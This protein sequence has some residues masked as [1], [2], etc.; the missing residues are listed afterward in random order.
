MPKRSAEG[1]VLTILWTGILADLSVKLEAFANEACEHQFVPQTTVTNILTRQGI[2]ADTKVREIMTAVRT[3]IT[4]QTTE[5]IT[6]RFNDFVIMLHN[7]ESGV[8]A[9]RLVT[10]LSKCTL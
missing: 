6:E 8:M 3:N 1:D 7:L 4:I 5:R 2:G 9:Q 10:E